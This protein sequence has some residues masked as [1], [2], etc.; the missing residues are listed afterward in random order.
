[1]KEISSINKNKIVKNIFRKPKR[2]KM[3]EPKK[4]QSFQQMPKKFQFAS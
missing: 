2:K 4:I 3:L 1:M